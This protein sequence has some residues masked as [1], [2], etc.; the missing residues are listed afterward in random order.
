MKAKRWFHKIVSSKVLPRR[1]HIS[2]LCCASL[3]VLPLAVGCRHIDTVS[4]DRKLIE[5]A[6][7]GSPVEIDALL[8]SG[9]HIDARNES[10]RTALML[11]ALKGRSENVEKLLARGAKIDETDSDQMT[12]LMWAAFGGSAKTVRALLA[13][14]ANINLRDVKGETALDWAGARSG[15]SEVIRALKGV[16]AHVP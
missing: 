9:A 1:S 14:G 11:A 7:N 12:A 16:N 15:N 2:S 3:L 8:N 5:A 10:K 4:L 6:K 13:H